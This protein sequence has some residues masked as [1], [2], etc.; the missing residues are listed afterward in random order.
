MIFSVQIEEVDQF[1]R[2]TL[3]GQHNYHA[4]MSMI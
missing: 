4:S 3:I 1:S 2:V